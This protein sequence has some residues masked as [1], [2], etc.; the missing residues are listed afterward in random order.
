M[1]LSGNPEPAKNFLMEPK[2]LHTYVH[3]Y[4]TPCQGLYTCTYSMRVL[5]L[6]NI[7]SVGQALEVLRIRMGNMVTFQRNILFACNA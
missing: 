6:M 1:G 4:S 5:N 7:F 3:A 2:M